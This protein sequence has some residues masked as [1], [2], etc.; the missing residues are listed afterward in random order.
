VRW[1]DDIDDDDADLGNVHTRP[2]VTVDQLLR[3]EGFR[4][5]GPRGRRR[6]LTGVAWIAF[7]ALVG[8]VLWHQ[9]IGTLLASGTTTDVTPDTAQSPAGTDTIAKVASMAG[10]SAAVPHGTHGTPPPPAAGAPNPPAV[11]VIPPATSFVS[12]RPRL[13]LHLHAVKRAVAPVVAQVVAPV[14]APAAPVVPAVN[15]TGPGGVL[16]Y[17]I[18]PSMLAS[19][20][21]ST[22]RSSFGWFDSGYGGQW[23]GGQ[24]YGGGYGCRGH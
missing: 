6:P 12:T 21:G 13:P 17:T 7:G 23:Y 18:Q 8:G 15:S 3:R 5:A 2:Q 19:T 14:V 16:L 22:T 9:P 4:P 24:S 1:F 11:V 20:Y 10:A